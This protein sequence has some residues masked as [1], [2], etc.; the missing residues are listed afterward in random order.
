M[1][2][3]GG[4]GSHVGNVR[5]ANQDRVYYGGELAAL[6]DG[7]G[8]HQGGERAAELAIGQ[9]RRAGA[10]L[11]EGDLV[12]MVL[13]ANRAVHGHAAENGLP[14]MGTTLV[15]LTLHTD[16]TMTVANV[17]D[18][19]A[20]WI[21]GDY[22][23]Q[24]TEDHSFVEDLVRQGRLTPAEAAIHPQRNILT[25]AVGIGIEVEV[26]RF[27]I[28]EPAIGDRFLLCSDGLFNEV[29]EDRILELILAA[30]DPVTAADALIE[31]ALETPCRDNVTVA[32]VEVVSDDEPRLEVVASESGD[33]GVITSEYIDDHAATTAQVPV[34]RGAQLRSVG[35]A[36]PRPVL[37]HHVNGAGADPGGDGAE[38]GRGAAAKGAGNVAVADVDTATDPTAEMFV[39]APGADEPTNEMPAIDDERL[40]VRPGSRLLVL[41]GG[42]LVVAGLLTGGYFGARS[43]A[44]SGYF[45]AEDPATGT[46]AVHQGR[47][48]GL[49]GLF[50]PIPVT[51]SPHAPEVLAQ[52]QLEAEA[53]QRFDDRA[54]ADAV[55]ASI[56]E[57][58]AALEAEADAAAG[59]SE[60]TS[61]TSSDAAGSD[62]NQ[63]TPGDGDGEG[64]GSSTGGG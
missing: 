46:L 29:S 55:L 16:N 42:L 31:A 19:R 40:E 51:A 36:G 41:V 62:S 21:R 17:G 34:V 30:P 39:D 25:R 8:G 59:P 50:D 4:T 60:S 9:F 5:E 23:S 61:S 56:D 13:A 11:S 15:A 27:P 63:L 49:F 28:E 3:L 37:D 1:R 6:A 18:S 64:G 35:E 38:P 45:I 10:E 44:R 7:M 53:D 2:L 33:D 47:E 24:V 58:L 57:R 32:V 48:G 22:M 12:D 26:D 14:G 52:V 43:Y 54:D 20:Y